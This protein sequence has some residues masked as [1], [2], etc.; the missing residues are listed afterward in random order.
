MPDVSHILG[1]GIDASRSTQGAD[2]HAQAGAKIIQATNNIDRSAKQGEEA[3]RKL[4]TT[5]TTAAPAATTLGT[6]ASQ[7]GTHVVRFTGGA[8]A[9]TQALQAATAASS[10]WVPELRG[11]NEV[12][13]PLFA[14]IKGSPIGFL[15]TGLTM[16]AGALGVFRREA[17]DAQ[18]EAA[19]LDDTFTSVLTSFDRSRAVLERARG[20]GDTHADLSQQRAELESL[21]KLSEDLRVK[22]RSDATVPREGL[23]RVVGRTLLGEGAVEIDHAIRVIEMEIR[24][25][26]GRLAILA[27]EAA[28][29]LDNAEARQ[30][31]IDAQEQERKSIASLIAVAQ[32]EA[33]IVGKTEDEKKR[34]RA[35]RQAEAQL[36]HLE[37]SER[38]RLVDSYLH[39]LERIDDLIRKEAEQKKASEDLRKAEEE[40][41]RT[42][43]DNV[44]AEN[45]ARENQARAR[46]AASADMTKALLAQVELEEHLEAVADEAERKRTAQAPTVAVDAIERAHRYVDDLRFEVSLLG[47]SNQERDRSITLHRL[48]AEA[49]G[50]NADETA[51]LR[52]E[53][54]RLLAD[55]SRKEKIVA[56]SNEISTSLVSGIE[57]AMLEWDNLG[58]VALS[59]LREIQL[60]ALRTFALQPLQ[61]FLSST[62]TSFMGGGSS[63]A[64][65]AGSSV[66]SFVSSVFGARGLV[67][68]RG[69]VVPF[70]R[71]GVPYVTQGPELFS[72]ANGGVGERGE[73]GPEI[74][75]P[76]EVGPDGRLGLNV[77]GLGGSN[78]TV[79]VYGVSDVESFRRNRRQIAAEAQRIFGH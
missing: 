27:E 60:M 39:E 3:L 8:N 50:L 6:A 73:A 42:V 63:A 16:A 14:L 72:L 24:I 75:A 28:R 12:I 21:I 9:M 48:E 38:K 51:D 37:A 61:Q 56:L 19:K 26:R 78:V 15:V 52:A 40:Y 34:L 36:T 55:R 45:R 10:K 30:K 77:R 25:R 66:M 20:F 59:V 17:K 11:V 18:T 44:A 58:E 54:E 5:M 1:I 47:L 68:D 41:R 70:A 35:A 22:R 23:E 46:D 67:L 64:S 13:S 43:E 79:N 32:F 29:E 71:G 4:G 33:S 31:A 76:A 7:A 2:I 57:R 53:V 49:K 62:L 74:V 65:S 69:Q